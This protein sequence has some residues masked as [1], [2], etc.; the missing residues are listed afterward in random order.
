MNF[1]GN[2]CLGQIVV[3][4][5][6]VSLYHLCSSPMRVDL[7]DLVVEFMEDCLDELPG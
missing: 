1:G 7:E 6:L 3:Q 5:Y 2:S 4:E